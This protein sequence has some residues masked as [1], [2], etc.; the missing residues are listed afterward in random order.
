MFSWLG[1]F[2]V[3]PV[4]N[5][6]L[7]GV[8]HIVDALIHTEMKGCVSLSKIIND[9]VVGIDVCSEFSV[10]AMLESNGSLIRKPFRIDHNPKGF[11][12]LLALRM[13][14]R[15][16]YAMSDMI[17]EMINRLCTDLYL[18][19]PGYLDVFG[20]PFGKASLEI[21][22]TY[23]SPRALSEVN[24]SELAL[25]ISKLSRK[26]VSWAMKKVD[27]LVEITT[28]AMSMPMAFDILSLKIKTHV[29]N[30]ENFQDRLDGLIKQLKAMI[31]SP[32]FPVKE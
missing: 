7:F 8:L 23:S 9:F 1:H 31:Q 12:S 21:L 20:N 27:A 10:V 5:A 17:T 13:M 26:T 15:E 32:D 2:W 6:R 24:S 25:M 28:R 4:S 22:K 11:N 18:L 29:E 19:F 30:I 14:S 3:L 16:Y